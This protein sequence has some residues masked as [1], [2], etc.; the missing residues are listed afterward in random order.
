MVFG[1]G[2]SDQ[3]SA[4][5]VAVEQPGV[6]G[7][8]GQQISLVLTVDGDVITIEGLVPDQAA[9][10]QLIGV[11]QS[12]YG[13]ENVLDQLVVDE[14]ATLEG[15]TIRIVGSAA[16]EDDRPAAIL[17]QFSADFESS[18]PWQRGRHRRHDAHPRCRHAD[19]R[20]GS[21]HPERRLP[22]EQ[23][24]VD[25]VAVAG[26]VW[27]ADN[28]DGSGL[29]VGATTWTD[30]LITMVGSA[31]STDERPDT[32]VGLVP[33]QIGTLVTVDTAALEV[34]DDDARR[35]EI[36]T[37]IND[38]VEANPIQFAPTLADIDPES[39][40]TLVELAGSSNR[41]R[42][43]RSRSSATPTASATIKRTWCCQ[44]IEQRPWWSAWRS[45]VSPTRE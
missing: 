5:E 22:D 19:R 4:D 31:S 12:A 32:F 27:G 10:D 42:P 41:S 25:L 44:K 36:Q 2:C 8:A 43:A 17:E 21:G 30:G 26:Q 6:V 13:A 11:A 16:R 33:A 9:K 39:D 23:S 35:L 14:G 7:G 15:G 18:Q 3:R 34:V 1:Y 24:I 28:V 37:E 20:R 40:D 38:L 29:S 45:S